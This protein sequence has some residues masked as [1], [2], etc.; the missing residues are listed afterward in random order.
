VRPPSARLLRRWETG[1]PQEFTALTTEPENRNW[2]IVTP[3]GRFLL[4]RFAHATRR[5]VLFRLQVTAALAAAELPVPAPIAARD[6]R[7]LIETGHGRYALY[8]WVEGRHR[9]GVELGIAQCLELGRVLGRLHT[10]LDR[11]TPPVQQSLLVPATRAQDAI[12]LAD[13]LLAAG[14]DGGPGLDALSER[15]LGDRRDL[16]VEFADHEPPAAETVTAGYVHG[17]L[18]SGNLLYGDFTGGVVAVMGWHGLHIA[19][20]AGEL[21]RAAAALFGHGDERGLDL[22]RVE[23]FVRGHAASFRLDAAQVQSAVHRL[24]WERLC[25]LQVL[26]PRE[27]GHDRSGDQAA[28]GAVALVEWWT[29]NLDRTLDVFAAPYGRSAG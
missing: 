3:G 9:D 16:L 2:R 12:A 20:F 13:R 26:E 23:A 10:E 19:P 21:V 8:S 6:G 1:E 5:Q 15:R 29:A 25:D 14:P 18:H 17:G 24:W 22:E 7:P 4:K 27:L 11:L 28:A